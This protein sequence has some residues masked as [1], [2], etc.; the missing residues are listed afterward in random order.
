MAKNKMGKVT[1]G[2]RIVS[3]VGKTLL[4]LDAGRSGWGLGFG[5][6]DGSSVTKIPKIHKIPK[7][8]LLVASFPGTRGLRLTFRKGRWS[9]QGAWEHGMC[10][11][12]WIGILDCLVTDPAMQVVIKTHASQ[13]DVNMTPRMQDSG[14]PPFPPIRSVTA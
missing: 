1:R 10:I 8:R 3:L 5:A 7:L 11:R 4:I 2:G 9:R 6:Q 12:R 13:I 14:P